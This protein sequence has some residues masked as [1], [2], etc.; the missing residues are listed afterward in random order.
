MMIDVPT[1]AA[2]E[3]IEALLPW[4]IGLWI[5]GAISAVLLA[6]YAAGEL[7]RLCR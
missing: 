2:F 5:A 7:R 6:I 4:L 1:S 3:F